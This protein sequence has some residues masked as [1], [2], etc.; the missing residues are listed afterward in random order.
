MLRLINKGKGKI[1]NVSGW[2]VTQ[3]GVP[4][5]V[6]Q[7]RSPL[8]S[9]TFDAS[10]DEETKFSIDNYVEVRHYMD[11]HA[12]RWLSTFDVN[13]RR[14]ETDEDFG[15]FNGVSIL[16]RLDVERTANV[17]DLGV[18][19]RDFVLPAG[20]P[21]LIGSTTYYTQAGGMVY[22]V[23]ASEDVV[24]VL[25]EGT[26]DG[27]VVFRYH[28]DGRL[29]DDVPVWPVYSDASDFSFPQSRLI[30]VD[31]RNS[32]IVVGQKGSL[33]RVKRFTLTGTFLNQWN[34]GFGLTGLATS[35]QWGSV[36]SDVYVTDQGSQLVRRYNPDTGTQI[37]SFGV[38]YGAA[39]WM[40]GIRPYNGKV[41][42]GLTE[43]VDN[44]SYLI[45]YSFS[46]TGVLNNQPLIRT[47]LQLTE[48]GAACPIK[49]SFA[50][51]G[52][53]HLVQSDPGANWM[54]L[55]KIRVVDSGSNGSSIRRT[56]VYTNG[57]KNATVA[58]GSGIMYA[59]GFAGTVRQ[60][61]AVPW[62]LDA[63]IL[64][65]IGLAAPNIPVRI[66]PISN[67]PGWG[68]LMYPG[69]V[70]NVWE[71]LCD[72]AAVWN[73]RII[74]NDSTI[75][76]QSWVQGAYKLPDDVQVEPL[77]ISTEGTARGVTV[78]NLQT[79]RTGLNDV[80]Y[81]AMNDG[82]RVFRA[83]VASLD[84]VTVNQG[85]SIDYV[86]SPTATS[87][88]TPTVGRYTVIDQ[89]N[90]IVSQTNWQNYGGAVIASR[91]S[92]PDDIVLKIVGP[93][94]EIPGT[95]A[96]YRLSTRGGNASL[97]V[98]GH[99]IATAPEDL[100][101][102]NGM[103]E[104]V[105]SRLDGGD[106]QSPFL[107]NADVAWKHGAWAAEMVGVQQ[108][109]R[110]RVSSK[111]TPKFEIIGD[112]PRGTS[113]LAG[114]LVF[115][116]DAYYRVDRV[117]WDEGSISMECIRHSPAGQPTAI[118][119]PGFEE[120]WGGQPAWMLDNY[121]F[122]YTAQDQA[123]APYRNPFD[124]LAIPVTKSGLFPDS[125]LYPSGFLYPKATVTRPLV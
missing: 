98:L 105:T 77:S 3:N 97:T 52:I 25:A 56:L 12:T 76:V 34:A 89:N 7:G 92:R 86:A 115:W 95:T 47:G 111:W 85:I 70:G 27:E 44:I 80:V 81:S 19:Q 2:T 5:I 99:G 28:N 87:S 15:S 39:G 51:N 9:L 29:W 57:M 110:F 74:A 46:N 48:S 60:Y 8:G 36:S 58:Y 41:Y 125:A 23:C 20:L 1:G 17:N 123:I 120:F 106:V 121:W 6:G 24:Y 101:I 96:P 84:Y 63:Y 88:G 91:G 61:A 45:L 53:L 75:Y 26:H 35:T 90:A 118:D 71:H 42:V 124:D 68:E 13:I 103:P 114:I 104:D 32:F 43:T 122:D 31:T 59:A 33:N 102:G 37:G 54:V 119:P 113:D 4:R 107:I 73:F 38:T 117:S 22:D 93:G 78:T 66:S 108:T 11:D 72:L 10:C 21:Y 16:Q 40:S 55:R 50:E 109:V 116:D 83:D 18:F 94:L 69:W 100:Y 64:Y 49:L 67:A 62:T 14:V 82:N 112:L 79:S 30:D 65:Y